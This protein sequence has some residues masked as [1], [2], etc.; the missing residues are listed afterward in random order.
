MVAVVASISV[1]AMVAG[2]IVAATRG[3]IVTARAEIDQAQVAAAADA[4]LALALH[5]LLSTD[6]AYRWSIDGRQRRLAFGHAQLVIRIE[7][8]RGKVPISLL[9]EDQLTRLLEEIGL[10]GNR[11]RV[12]RDSLLDW[13]DDDDDSRPDGA[14]RAYY[15]RS[16][17]APRNGS[18]LTID[19]LTRVRGFDA[20]LVERLRPAITVNYGSGPF[21]ARYAH[22][23]ALGIMLEGGADS[24]LAIQR[25]RELAG[26]VTALELDTR[27]DIVGKPL[28]II[29]E[30]SLADGPRSRRTEIIELTGSEARPYVVRSYE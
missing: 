5:G 22:P 8:E 10:S 12:A 18:L 29:V 16:G 4:G 28:S 30:A 9:E 11:L 7:D 25:E 1:F 17:F 3:S 19:E 24:P 26:Q 14:E 15:R 6:P 21:D 2:A 20:A 27:A 13:V 23:L